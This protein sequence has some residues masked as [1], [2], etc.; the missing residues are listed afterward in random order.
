MIDFIFWYIFGLL[1]VTNIQIVWAFT[2]MP[3]YIFKSLNIKGIKSQEVYTREE[4]EDWLLINLNKFGELLSC[5]IC[6]S[7]HTSW[8]TSFLI[9]FLFFK[10]LNILFMP[11]L[12]WPFMVFLIY[13]FLKKLN[14]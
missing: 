7:T 3:L 6:M 12:T 11:V 2:N 4:F 1:V 9:Y 13:S 8:I 14:Q 10:N 5:P